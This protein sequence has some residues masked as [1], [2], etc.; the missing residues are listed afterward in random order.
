MTI[1]STKPGLTAVSGQPV[2]RAWET[3][4]ASAAREAAAQM[5]RRR[6]RKYLRQ[7]TAPYKVLVG[8]LG[9]AWL[10]R[11]AVWVTGDPGAVAWSV[12]GLA[13]VSAVI[14]TL[15]VRRRIS[16]RLRLWLGACLVAACSWLVLAA[17]TGV[18]WDTIACLVTGGVGL[19]TPH[20][21]RHRIPNVPLS[22]EPR[23]GNSIPELWK[24]HVAVNGGPL[25][26]SA[27]T[28]PRRGKHR[29]R[30]DV[31]LRPGKQSLSTALSQVN[32]IASGLH[33]ADEDIIIERHPSG[34]G[35]VLMLTVVRNSPVK[36]TQLFN[37]PLW[38]LDANGRGE[39]EL[40]WFA[41]GVGRAT[42]K[43]LT[44]N[45][46]WG[47]LIVGG[48]GS[49]KSRLLEGLIC[50]MRASGLI[51]VFYG[52]PQGGTSSDALASNATW[53]ARGNDQIIEMLRRVDC[54]LEW[55]GIQNSAYG[56]SGFT[57]SANRPGI[58]V[59][60]DECHMIL[61]DERY[62][63]EATAIC[64]NIARVGRKL[65]IGLILASQTGD[66]PTFGGSQALRDGIRLGNTVVLRTTNRTTKGI[67]GLDFEPHL[68]PE[69]P[70]FGYIVAAVGSTDR[71]APFRADYL[72]EL[73]EEE[74][75]AVYEGA[76]PRE[77]TAHWWLSRI[78][79][80]S[81]NKDKLM[82]RA[83]GHQFAQR[84][85]T[86]Q[87]ARQEQQDL[88]NAFIEGRLEGQTLSTSATGLST[89]E[90][91]AN[92]A[93]V[94]EFPAAPSFVNAPVNPAAT[95]PV[96]AGQPSEIPADLTNGQRDVLLAIKA[97]KVKKSHIMA[98]T[99]LSDSGVIKILRALIERG[100]VIQPRWGHYLL[101]N[102]EQV[103]TATAEDLIVDQLLTEAINIV[104]T[105]RIAT[106][107]SLARHLTLTHEQASYLLD[108]LA[109][110]GVISEPAGPD[111]ERT[112]L[113][114]PEQLD[115]AYAGLNP[116]GED[117]T[118]PNAEALPA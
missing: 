100:L 39:V 107:T 45:S 27:L 35:S 110:A 40:G 86:M 90:Q 21:R 58:M 71:T 81:L 22:R 36:E 64:E 112:V 76:E 31:L 23:I 63:E 78:K 42:W 61:S 77:G 17:D 89:A 55:R 88:L 108:R 43:V 118:D 66:L 7:Q 30:Y 75:Q 87:A 115:K 20:W 11:A 68:L 99:G 5:R 113:M 72:Q 46:I 33:V 109:E 15:V 16:R 69:I 101:S 47:G 1:T 103:A 79:D 14:V 106:S 29:E 104:V 51:T 12:A 57:A 8:L 28:N 10:A 93:Q 3:A 80:A 60:L 24:A 59:V 105:S 48:T 13:G 9:T 114:S 91:A 49:G 70:G 92:L 111:A 96:A 38:T 82:I 2:D 25:P 65:G 85:E 4:K 73:S 52:D 53:G 18:D 102:G 84:N 6:G 26:D 117:I 62:G 97:G 50:S 83:L 116:A 74:L 67:L 41:D 37:G 32:L 94:L 44:R 34:D 56:L 95:A 98:A 54:A 19:A